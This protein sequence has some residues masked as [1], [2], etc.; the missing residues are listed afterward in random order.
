MSKWVSVKDELPLHGEV[1]LVYRPNVLI[2]DHTDKPIRCAK[3]TDGGFDCHHQPL[4]WARIE[5][6]DGWN[7]ELDARQA[8]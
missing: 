4:L 7:D 1:V 2:D 3:F 8:A 6:P 5:K